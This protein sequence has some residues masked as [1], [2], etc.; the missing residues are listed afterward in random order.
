MVHSNPGKNVQLAIKYREF[1]R[2]GFTDA[3]TGNNY[4]FLAASDSQW[5]DCTCVFF[6]VSGPKLPPIPVKSMLFF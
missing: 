6:C 5:R 3:K 2:E 4:E 1:L